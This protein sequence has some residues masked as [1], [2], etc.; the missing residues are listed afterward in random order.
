M[1]IGMLRRWLYRDKVR[2][3]HKRDLNSVL[4]ELGIMEQ[5]ESGKTNCAK[6]G[7]PVTSETIQCLFIENDEIKVCCDNMNCYERL[8]QEREQQVRSSE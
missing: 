3:V 7:K 1:V 2:A 6:C 8:I 4:S 5:V